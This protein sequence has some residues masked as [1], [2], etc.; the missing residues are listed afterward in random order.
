MLCITMRAGDYVTLGQ[1]T[2]VQ[3]ERLN[4]DRA[5]IMIHAPREVPILRGD[6]LERE[7]GKRPACVL[8]VPEPY[9]RQLPWNHKKKEALAELRDTLAHME[10]SPETQRIREKLDAIFP[11]SQEPAENV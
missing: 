8:D 9:I 10:D 7:G 1:D 3:F 2:V 4:G 6:V 5:R 11:G